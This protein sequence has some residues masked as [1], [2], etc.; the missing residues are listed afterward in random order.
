MRLPVSFVATLRMK[1]ARIFIVA[2]L[3]GCSS[4]YSAADLAGRYARAVDGGM[5]TIELEA[6]GTYIHSYTTKSG[7]IDHQDGAWTLE[8]LQ[9]GPTVVLDDFRPLLAEKVR[10]QGI[11]LLLIKRSFWTLYLITNIDLDEGY[12]RQS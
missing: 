11:Y 6:N 3:A 12:R 2:L 1:F 9:A 4:H 7:E 5:D 8:D 10:G